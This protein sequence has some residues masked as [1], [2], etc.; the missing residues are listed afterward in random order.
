MSL[1]LPY[2]GLRPFRRDE[3]DLFF[4]R[5]DA[6]DTMVQRLLATRFLG[7]LGASGS[8]KSS[9]VRTGLFEALE[10]GLSEGGSRWRI[11]DCRPGGKPIANIA[12]ALR[13][14][15]QKEEAFDD[16][17]YLQT[18]LRRGPRAIVEW[19]AQGHIQPGWK[20][21]IL[22]DQFEELFN[23]SSVAAREDADA[24]AALLV[25]SA[26]SEQAPIHVVV[27][28]RSDYFGACGAHP[29]LAEKISEGIFL[30]P[31]ITRDGC[32]DAI[33]C[34]SAIVGF[35]IAAGL[36]NELLNDMERFA[37]FETAGLG[38]PTRLGRQADQLPLMQYVLNRMW[39]RAVP[40]ATGRIALGLDD[41]RAIGGLEGVLDA[42]GEEVMAR[43][44]EDE[45]AIGRVFR[46]LV[47]GSSVA[48]ATRDPH[49]IDEIA[50]IAALDPETVTRIVLAF[51]S[52]DCLFLRVERPVTGQSFVDLNHESLIRQWHRLS[53]WLLEES[54]AAETWRALS[55]ETQFWK[56]EGEPEGALLS[57]LA[58]A[59]R[60]E[61]WDA[62]Q[63]NSAWT[64]RYGDTDG[65]S[66][67]EVGAFLDRSEAN[68][69][70]GEKVRAR[71]RR[72][73]RLAGSGGVAVILL[74][75]SAAGAQQIRIAEAKLRDVE[76]TETARKKEEGARA[77][78]R[79]G[80]LRTAR[81]YAQLSSETKSRQDA[82][83]KAEKAKERALASEAK[84]VAAAASAI[85]ER[86]RAQAAVLAATTAN[87]AAFFALQTNFR[88]IREQQ[89]RIGTSADAVAGQYAQLA[90]VS[91]AFRGGDPRQRGEFAAQLSLA[92]AGAE[93]DRMGERNAPPDHAARRAQELAQAARDLSSDPTIVARSL[94]VDGKAHEVDQRFA[95]AAAAYEQALE[96]S[97]SLPE[98]ASSDLT[99]EASAEL[100]TLAWRRGDLQ[101]AQGFVD[102][103]RQG[104]Q[105]VRGT[106]LPDI[107]V[108]DGWDLRGKEC[109][110]IGADVAL[111]R[112]DRDAA[113]ASLR[114]LAGQPDENIDLQ[115]RQL[116]LKLKTITAGGRQSGE[117]EFE[118]SDELMNEA[119]RHYA[120]NQRTEKYSNLYAGLLETNEDFDEAFIVRYPFLYD[121]KTTL[122]YL[123][124]SEYLLRKMLGNAEPP[125]PHS[126]AAIG[127]RGDDEDPDNF[128]KAFEQIRRYYL[129]HDVLSRLEA[130]QAPVAPGLPPDAE[131]RA[132][133]LQDIGQNLG[134][135]FERTKAMLIAMAKRDNLLEDLALSD[136]TYI[137]PGDS[138]YIER[139]KSHLGRFK[140]QCT[141]DEIKVPPAILTECMAAAEGAN[142]ALS[143]LFT[144]KTYRA[145]IQESGLPNAW[146]NGYDP[147]AYPI[148]G[149]PVRG[150][151]DLSYE[152]NG[153][154][155]LFSTPENLAAFGR[156]PARYAPQY[157][158]YAADWM[159]VGARRPGDPR[160]YCVFE[161]RL[162]LLAEY[163]NRKA[164]WCATD[165]VAAADLAW[166]RLGQAGEAASADEPTFS[167]P[168]PGVSFRRSGLARVYEVGPGTPVLAP[169]AG[170]VSA[171]L[172][173]GPRNIVE[174]VHVDG[175]Y[176]VLRLAKVEVSRGQ[177]IAGGTRIGTAAEAAGSSPGTVTWELRRRTSAR[178]WQ[179][180][181]I[182][183]RIAP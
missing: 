174:I 121:L 87:A 125:S 49:T 40:R 177:M 60:R 71:Q 180:V 105:K 35:D 166:P 130:A 84:A 157:S 75:L 143:P 78:E 37:P 107:F 5:D 69:L 102:R 14:A 57:G 142:Q 110:R 15:S 63:P 96:R 72:R 43:L 115:S 141:E 81:L 123:L 76:R 10:G 73:L 122:G 44:A 95:E 164:S 179:A 85:A 2:P 148:R 13:E 52:D 62:Q 117:D 58:L 90:E 132:K 29:A 140:R 70:E 106:V 176:S 83:I 175:T 24:Y 7:V 181:P 113:M 88:Q 152:W 119:R 19:C 169:A 80:L 128:G 74:L 100:A 46:A 101:R 82:V 67:E 45:A 146:L 168:V 131:P 173:I 9:L 47:R 120:P 89:Q 172:R 149:R 163:E 12:A 153:K 20:L 133:L 135:S 22:V 134:G 64:A 36:L 151:T 156:A 53:G 116:E 66:V 161:G 183:A 167:S 55:R 126:V 145:I 11:A 158:G 99:V 91:S 33:V 108:H 86:N 147:V 79:E 154:L 54:Q 150:R 171:L 109:E 16:P 114:Q 111:A 17:S 31:R 92:S 178:A 50:A 165:T 160:S 6:I 56:S 127:S 23:Y 93:L 21:L 94:I 4:G 30:T 59:R 136:R 118:V 61:W 1:R 104:V 77:R 28:M 42:H 170:R 129:M 65:A 137:L 48:L 103:C 98:P 32:R 144:N 39:L 25:E 3:A 26:K 8:G 34:P 124:D 68:R 155:I 97:T 112:G 138:F 51:G 182:D 41:Y 18:H 27:T 162:F 159:A 38:Q 139:V